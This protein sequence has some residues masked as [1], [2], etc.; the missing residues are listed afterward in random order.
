MNDEEELIRAFIVPAKR[1]RYLAMVTNAKRR[2]RFLGE[3]GHFKSLDPRY[4]R[5]IPSSKQHPPEIALLLSKMSAPATCKVTSEDS[6]IDGTEM[7]LLDALKKVV[8]YQMGAFLS[9]VPGKLAYFEDEDGR[10]ILER[11]S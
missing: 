7:P 10:W 1:E 5:S 8:G 6:E 9:C 3:L 2:S 4:V 11:H